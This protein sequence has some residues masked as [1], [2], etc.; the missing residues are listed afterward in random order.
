VPFAGPGILDFGSGTG[1]AAV[2]ECTGAE[3]CE[4]RM[5]VDFQVGITLAP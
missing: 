1:T 4:L 5:V 3:A 2:R